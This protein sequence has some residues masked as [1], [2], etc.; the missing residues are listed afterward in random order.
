MDTKNK[1]INDANTE[2]LKKNTKKIKLTKAY[3]LVS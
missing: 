3:D 1:K 2:K